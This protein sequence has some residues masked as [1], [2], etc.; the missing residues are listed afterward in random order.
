MFAQFFEGKTKIKVAL[1][2]LLS[3]VV[4]FLLREKLGMTVEAATEVSVWL[5]GMF[6]AVVLGHTVTDA[7]ANFGVGAANSLN[8]ADD[9]KKK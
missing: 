1:L 5:S 6:G 8:E 7:A 3:V 9:K 2:N 4:I